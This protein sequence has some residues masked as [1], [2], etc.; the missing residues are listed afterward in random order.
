MQIDSEV[1]SARQLT[2]GQTTIGQTA[3]SI[4]GGDFPSTRGLFLRASPDN[5]VNVYVGRAKVQV[6]G[7][8]GGVGIAPGRELSLPVTDIAAI[9]AIA[10][11]GGQVL[12]WM[13]V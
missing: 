10:S 7:P 1:T 4:S 13:T 11:T 5:S 8:S 3:V 9:F 6:S 12:E 2:H